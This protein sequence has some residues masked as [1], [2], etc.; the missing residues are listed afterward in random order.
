MEC[1]Q[2][3]SQM[4]YLGLD[5]DESEGFPAIIEEWV[6]PACDNRQVNTVYVDRSYDRFEHYLED[7]EG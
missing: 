6:C 1:S 3:Y 5:D 2:C 4:E 7:L